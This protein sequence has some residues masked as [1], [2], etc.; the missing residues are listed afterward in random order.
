MTQSI[1]GQTLKAKPSVPQL[2]ENKLSSAWHGHRVCDVR[3]CDRRPKVFVTFWESNYGGEKRHYSARGPARGPRKERFSARAARWTGAGNDV[4]RRSRG[5][6]RAGAVARVSG[7]LEV[8]YGPHNDLSAPH[9]SR[10]R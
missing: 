1:E 8:R 9:R 6:V 2:S 4:R 7:D 10:Q 5:G 3:V